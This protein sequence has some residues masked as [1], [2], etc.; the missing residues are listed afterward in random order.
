MPGKPVKPGMVGWMDMSDT[1]VQTNW[2]NNRKMGQT[3]ADVNSWDRDG[4]RPPSL[5]KVLLPVVDDIDE[6][7]RE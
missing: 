6:S 1:A 7:C 5:G 4:H 3:V 2:R